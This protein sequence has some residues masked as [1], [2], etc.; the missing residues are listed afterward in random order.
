MRKCI[1][2]HM[3]TTKA[4]ISLC[5]RAVWSAPLLFKLASVAEQAGLNLTWLKI[6]E[7]KFSCDVAH[8][9]NVT[10][11]NAFWGYQR[12]ETQ[13]GCSASKA[14]QTEVINQMRLN[15]ACSASKAAQ[16]E[17]IHQIRLK[18]VAQL[19]KL[20]RLKLST[21]W[22]SNQLAQPPKLLRLRLSTRWD[23]N[24]LLSLQSCSD[25]GYQPD[26]MGV[27]LQQF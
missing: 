12:D 3:G 11:K 16:T 22:D 2:C 10:R 9:S 15:P 7:D 18:P 24:R 19:P 5:I 13:T 8:M 17:I 25:W 21:R 26:E 23:S 20:L 14:A 27:H 4:Q 1:L 6:P